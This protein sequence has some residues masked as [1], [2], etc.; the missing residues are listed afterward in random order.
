MP[1]E[2]LRP[3]Q[4]PRR[5]SGIDRR[6]ELIAEEGV[7][8][9]LVIAFTHELSLLSPEA[10][11]EQVLV[12][13][14]GRG[15]R[16]RRR[17]LPLRPRRRGRR[18]D[19]D[20]ARREARLRRH[21]GVAR[22][23]R[24]RARLVVLDP[25]ARPPGRGHARDAPARAPAVARRHGRARLR[26]RPRARRADRE[27]ALDARPRRP[28]ARHLRRLRRAR[29]RRGALSGRDLGRRQPDLRRRRG[30]GRRGVP[31]RLRGR[32]LRPAAARRVHALPA[33]RAGVR[34]RRGARRA[35]VARHRDR[36]RA[37]RGV[38]PG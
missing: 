31:D 12:A 23:G 8:E 32:R 27:P 3:G 14:G 15:A 36:A 6:A 28:G 18:G 4:V 38:E 25:R 16:R 7:D 5:L 19:A 21:L 13:Q 22:D 11:A 35:D 10:F 29:P 20:R 2:I 1:S 33:P 24:R 9:L 17:E 37:G 26:A 30:H 34:V